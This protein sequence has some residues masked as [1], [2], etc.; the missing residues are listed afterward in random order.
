MVLK[1]MRH[2]QEIDLIMRRR[3]L[4][5][6][7]VSP[8]S[9]H[10]GY[11][12][13]AF[14]AYSLLAAFFGDH[15]RNL[16]ERGSDDWWKGQALLMSYLVIAR[17]L[18]SFLYPEVSAHTSGSRFA[19]PTIELDSWRN[20]DTVTSFDFV[21]DAAAWIDSRPPRP[22]ELTDIRTSINRQVIHFDLSRTEPR[23]ENPEVV[24]PKERQWEIGAIWNLI[25]PSLGLL[26]EN[27]DKDLVSEQFS[28]QFELALRA[29]AT[30]LE[31]LGSYPHFADA[32]QVRT[33]DR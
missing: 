30:D 2:G 14:S 6:D 7:R 5:L 1:S 16:A 11:A 3:P 13:S 25:R 29:E 19:R 31:S 26:E 24:P 9:D 28:K 17:E 18:D 33:E 15:P 20:R 21:Q 22:T 32:K 4:P 10:L 23:E 12:V 27:F 8:F